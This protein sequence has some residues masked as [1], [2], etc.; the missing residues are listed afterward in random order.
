MFYI[1]RSS[2]KPNT[3][4]AN[5]AIAYYKAIDD[6]GVDAKVVILQADKDRSRITIPFK[7]LKVEYWWER[8]KCNSKVARRVQYFWNLI[9]F[10]NK[11]QT[12]DKVYIYGFSHGLHSLL[13][14]KN[15]DVY[16][17]VT[18]HPFVH[19]VSTRFLFNTHHN[20]I[21]DCKRLSGLFV[22][23]DFLKKY[24]IKEGVPESIIHIVNMFVDVSRFNGIKKEGKERYICYC[25]NGNN[26]KD[27]VN[28]LIKVF[29]TISGRFPDVN[30]LIVG[31]MQQYYRDEEDNVKL[32]QELS[33]QNRVVFLGLLPAKDIPQVLVNAELLALDRPDTLQNKA[34]FP[35]KLGEYLLSGTPVVVTTVGDIPL[36]LKD[37][38][39]A[40]L[41][42]PGDSKGYASK[43]MWALEHSEEARLIGEKGQAVAKEYFNSITETNKL[44]NLVLS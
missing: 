37:Q 33:I 32:V 35:T 8:F 42:S 38:E 18:E 15:I 2:F 43:I 34:G 22:I 16:L 23:S 17:E 25:G 5:R 26:R 4:S 21:D 6:L 20:S 14:K 9:K 19:P 13:T 28:E 24:Y 44:V 31:P 7:C 29:A 12:G 11:V 3:A 41:V 39:S 10:I 36:F 27:K 1:L 40:L 30:L